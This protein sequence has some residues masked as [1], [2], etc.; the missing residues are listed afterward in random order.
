MRKLIGGLL[1]ACGLA[2]TVPDGALR[3]DDAQPVTPAGKKK[4]GK[5]PRRWLPP[6]NRRPRPPSF[7]KS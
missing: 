6:P 2:L 4:N 1:L 5:S 3:A 7:T